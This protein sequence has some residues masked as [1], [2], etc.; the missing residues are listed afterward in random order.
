M[1]SRV[2]AAST[3]AGR[4]HKGHDKPGKPLVPKVE[5]RVTRAR[6]DDASGAGA[7]KRP[8]VEGTSSKAIIVADDSDGEPGSPLKRKR[9]SRTNL[10]AS[11]PRNSDVRRLRDDDTP[12]AKGSDD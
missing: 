5:P 9:T 3:A 7:S 1:M 12:T 6:A 4:E 11:P 2:N 8:R 10:R